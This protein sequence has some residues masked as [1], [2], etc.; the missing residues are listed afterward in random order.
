MRATLI[1]KDEI[2]VRF[3]GLD[4]GTLEKAAKRLTFFVPGFQ[5]MPKFKLKRWDGTISLFKKTGSTW[6]HLVDEVLPILEA[7]GYDDIDVEDH[8]R[9]YSHITSQLRHIRDDFFGDVRLEGELLR[10]RDYQVAAVNE[11]IDNGAG[12][13]EMATGSGKAQP[14]DA[15]VHTP[16]GWKRMG[17]ISIGDTIT[18][19]NGT[20]EV[21][22]VYPQGTLDVFEVTMGDGRKVRA[23]G[24]HLWYVWNKHWR[25]NRGRGGFSENLSGYRLKTTDEIR[26][27]LRRASVELYV[28]LI[29]VE[30]DP[31]DLP[32]P[33]YLM[34]I[35]LGDGTF[36]HSI[37]FSSQD[38]HIVEAVN[39]LTDEDYEAR[40]QSGY[41]YGIRHIGQTET[42]EGFPGKK[43]N[44]YQELT[45]HLG[46][47]GHYSYEK[48]IPEIYLLGSLKQR[49]ELICGLM[50]TDGTVCDKG[51]VS[52]STSSEKLAKDM[53]ALLRSVGCLVKPKEKITSHRISYLLH[54]SHDTP[55]ILFRLP[56]KKERASRNVWR[57]KR[58]KNKILRVE[59]VG[60]GECQCIKVADP[61]EVYI[62]DEY[63]PTHNTLVCAALSRVY[64]PHGRVVVI[65]P[66]I[67][68]ILQTQ[69]KFRQVGIEPGIWYGPVKDRKDITIATWQ[70][71]DHF[72]ELFEGVMCVIVDE[73]HQAKAP[74]L[75]EM[76]SGPARN[77]PF[78]FGCTGTLPKEDIFRYQIRANLGPKI[79]HLQTWELQDRGVLAEATVYQLEFQDMSNPRYV[80]Y[81]KTFEDWADQINFLMSDPKRL[82]HLAALIVDVT[83][84]SGNTLVLIPYRKHG[85]ALQERIPGSV[86]L[87]GRD[88]DRMTQYQEFNAADGRVMICTYGIASEGLDLPRIFT[89]VCV[90]AGK[91][92]EKVMQSMGRGLRKKAGE[93]EHL[94]LLDVASDDGIS[95][96]HAKKRKKLFIEAKQDFERVKVAYT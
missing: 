61:T 3:R 15:H 48:F 13:L 2:N 10:L 55:E 77:V 54:I 57:R 44:R 87:D 4:E 41:D 52:F 53:I 60:K 51:S 26:R 43:V 64:E 81:R 73:V 34:G 14:V 27:S 5:F 20:T 63:V 38:P 93:K 32:I 46:L 80:T 67:D 18:T 42:K 76:M 78:R 45:K 17:D 39:V 62:T 72:P 21:I 19:F 49:L 37:G 89:L 24:D 88:R 25:E 91:K 69:S 79:F 66:T 82:E 56:R 40:H 1:V 31:V 23:S 16:K 58:L 59:K 29:G 94:V 9:D 68:L 83:Q 50:D 33:P 96:A 84:R 90:E 86:S 12:L 71:L 92:F 7:Q 6:L 8:R 28:P 35:L 65:V 11:A 85:K 74:V 47:W 70:S 22:G 30:Q 36:R 75:S 95:A